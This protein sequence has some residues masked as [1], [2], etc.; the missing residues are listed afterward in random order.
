[1]YDHFGYIYRLPCGKLASEVSHFEDDALAGSDRFL[2]CYANCPDRNGTNHECLGKFLEVIELTDSDLSSIAID[3]Y[4]RPAAFDE[5][6]N[7]LI[8]VYP[9]VIMQHWHCGWPI[10]V[11]GQV[12]AYPQ[13]YLSYMRSFFGGRYTDPILHLFSGSVREGITIDNDPAKGALHC[14]D[15]LKKGI[16][17]PDNHF[18]IVFADPPYD[19]KDYQAS[20][21]HY[22]KP[23]VP[24]YSFV[25]EAVRVTKVGGFFV[26]LHVMPY[27]CPKECVRFAQIS[28][29]AGSTMVVR[30]A[31]IFQKV[32]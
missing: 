22:K 6:G 8:E 10:A 11:D 21:R 18:N 1:M 20:E 25:K 19:H 31:S 27:N 7:Q 15:V 17:Y 29:T 5:A 26:V 16:P 30:E 14:I 32:E 13:R 3:K 4:Q 28:V 12:G 23:P 24:R 9:G 2:C